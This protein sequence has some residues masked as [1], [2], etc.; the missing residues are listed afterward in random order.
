MA[1]RDD[2]KANEVAAHAALARAYG[3]GRILVYT[4]P[5]IIN[6]PGS[7][8]YSIAD[9]YVPPLVLFGAS[10][11]LLIEFGMLVWIAGMVFVILFWAFVQPPIVRWRAGRRAKRIAFA[12][13]E[14][15][16]AHWALGG[17]A[18]VLKDWPDRNCVAPKGDWRAFATDYLVEWRAES[19]PKAEA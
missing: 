13:P 9:V 10:I 2:K 8:A 14:G 15:M 4:D 12:T 11:T 6:R 16:K 19:E 1:R 18:L 7:P 17:F 3:D 5:R